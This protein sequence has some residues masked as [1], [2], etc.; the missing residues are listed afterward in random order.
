M[1]FKFV[2]ALLAIWQLPFASQ[3]TLINFDDGVAG[4]IIGNRYAGQGVSFTNA[5]RVG[6]FGLLGASGPYG[7]SAIGS[8]QWF[9]DQ[10]VTAYFSDDIG[11][12]S[13]VGVDVGNNGLRLA[14]YDALSGGNLVDFDEAFGTNLGNNEFFT[15]SVTAALIKRVEFYQIQRNSIDGIVIEDLRFENHT[16]LPLPAPLTLMAVGLAGWRLTTNRGQ[17]QTRRLCRRCHQLG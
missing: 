7:I 2:I 8:F 15:L 17:R 4:D 10:P 13:L 12:V 6:N 14:A 5:E 3:A 11:N 16:A 1:N 9:A